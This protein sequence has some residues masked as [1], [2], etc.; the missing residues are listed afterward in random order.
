M[1][2][3]IAAV[4]GL[5]MVATPAFAW[6]NVRAV[7]DASGVTEINE[8]ST[9][10]GYDGTEGKMQVTAYVHE[11]VKNDGTLYFNNEIDSPGAWEMVESKDMW[12]TGDTKFKKE[13]VWWTEDSRTDGCGDN[14]V[15]RYPTEA[16]IFVGFYTE[17]FTD[18]LE[19]DNVADLPVEGP[20]GE[21]SSNYLLKVWDTDDNFYF[22]EGVGINMLEDCTPH[23]P[24][25]WAFPECE[26]PGC[27]C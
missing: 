21:F 27:V 26:C 10:A 22:N 17:T 4:L 20:D 14:K 8:L 18:E 3:I 15:M 7:L 12:G 16:H 13:V 11:G 9:I 2:K 1:N 23:V 19:I 5:L 25:T 24:H 6:T